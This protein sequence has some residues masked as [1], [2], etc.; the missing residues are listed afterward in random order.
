MKHSKIIIFLFA[1]LLLLTA[2]G[3][4]ISTQDY[5][6]VVTENKALKEQ[7]DTLS[8]ENQA[9]S[10]ENESLSVDLLDAEAEK[11]IESLPMEYFNAWAI[12]SFGDNSICLMSAD[13]LHLQCI[14]GNTYSISEEGISTLWS[15]LL[16]SLKTLSV[17]KIPSSCETISISFLDPSGTHIIDYYLNIGNSTNENL[18]NSIMCNVMYIDEITIYMDKIANDNTNN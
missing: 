7:V 9:L 10:A 8:A 1:L 12:T 6:N 11:T 17:V 4:D 16:A 18:V 5:I 14:A 13:A 15:D 3:N 2:C